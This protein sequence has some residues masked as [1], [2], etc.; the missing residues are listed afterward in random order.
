MEQPK[1]EICSIRIMFPV[2]SDDEAIAIKK[3][4]TDILSGSPDVV[5]QFSINSAPT[6]RSMVR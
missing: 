3:K 2:N 6:D 5:I 4:I 1:K